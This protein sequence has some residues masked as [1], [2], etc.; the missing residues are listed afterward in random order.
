MRYFTHLLGDSF[1]LLFFWKV[2]S[3]CGERQLL[4]DGSELQLENAVG[5]MYVIGLILV[6]FKEKQILCSI[7][8]NIN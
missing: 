8:C 2:E 4:W 5:F 3:R 6:S 1:F 7:Q